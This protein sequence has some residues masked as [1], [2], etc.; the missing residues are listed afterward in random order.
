MYPFKK[1]KKKRKS[2]NNRMKIVSFIIFAIFVSAAYSLTLGS[3]RFYANVLLTNKEYGSG[4]VFRSY[5][6]FDAASQQMRLDYHSL[7]G[8]K[9]M[10]VYYNYQ[11]KDKYQVCSGNCSRATWNGDIPTFHGTG[12]NFNQQGSCVTP[13]WPGPRSCVS[14]CKTFNPNPA[15]PTGINSLSFNDTA[16]TQLCLVRWSPGSGFTY[17]P[18]WHVQQY[19]TS[20][21]PPSVDDPG[22][23]NTYTKVISGISCPAPVCNSVLDIAIVLD[24]SG[25]ITNNGYW[26]DVQNFAINLVGA[27]DIGANNIRAGLI[28]FSGDYCSKNFT[29]SK[30]IDCPGGSNCGECGGL[31]QYGK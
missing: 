29:G 13:D 7:N 11:T 30:L 27:L 14:N 15:Q 24:E 6:W 8:A 18:E 26:D 23:S 19:F 20:N 21:Y 22:N 2:F 4:A 28:F 25:S 31:W 3:Q 9:F 16:N 17:G 1:K 10:S 5:V 12:S